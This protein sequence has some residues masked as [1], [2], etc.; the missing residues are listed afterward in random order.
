M[1]GQ[2]T[3]GTEH[4]LLEHALGEAE[5]FVPLLRVVLC[6][7]IEA[8]DRDDGVGRFEELVVP[9][10]YG[11]VVDRSA[12]AEEVER[13]AAAEAGAVPAGGDEFAGQRLLVGVAREANALR[14]KR[15]VDEAGAVD[16][17]A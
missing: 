3:P 10:V 5:R 4:R 15:G 8:V 9:Q 6:R 12:A 13:V 16:A 2:K 7:R 1:H 17:V 14:A 11:G